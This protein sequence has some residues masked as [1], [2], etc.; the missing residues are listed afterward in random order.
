MPT[1]EGKKVITTAVVEQAKKIYNLQ[2]KDVHPDQGMPSS[3][4]IKEKSKIT[5][6]SDKVNKRQGIGRTETIGGNT[7]LTKHVKNKKI[8]KE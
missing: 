3:K 5:K 7:E 6:T 8:D 2:N 1:E 4:F